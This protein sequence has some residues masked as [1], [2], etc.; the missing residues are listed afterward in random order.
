[1]MYF[2]L[3]SALSRR[4]T[5][6]FLLWAVWN[7]ILKLNSAASSPALCLLWHPTAAM[8]ESRSTV[9]WNPNPR[10]WEWVCR[11]GHQSRKIPLP[12]GTKDAELRTHSH[13]TSSSTARVLHTP[14]QA[15]A[16]AGA[17]SFPGAGCSSTGIFQPQVKTGWSLHG[18]AWHSSCL[19][20]VK[21]WNS[22]L[23]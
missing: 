9:R 5:F 14:A 15:T 7:L 4:S 2:S 20:R 8:A 3:S 16:M 23:Q 19:A 11:R 18:T 17:R 21:D 1:M 22:V 12:E 10:G 6:A 13:H